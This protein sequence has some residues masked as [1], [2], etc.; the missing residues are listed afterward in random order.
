MFGQF[1]HMDYIF[2]FE[3]VIVHDMHVVDRTAVHAFCKS[4]RQEIRRV[5][6]GRGETDNMAGQP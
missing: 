6:A 4:Q 1:W 5:G 2:R 3:Y